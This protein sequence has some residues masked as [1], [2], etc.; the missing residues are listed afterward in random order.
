MKENIPDD[1]FEFLDWCVENSFDFESERASTKLASNIEE[2]KNRIKMR[3]NADQITHELMV[4]VYKDIVEDYVW[5]MIRPY[6]F[7][8]ILLA[9]CANYLMRAQFYIGDA[10]IYYFKYES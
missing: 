5:K 1:P 3:V 8:V 6:I 10:L 4:S 2:R 9:I 7:L